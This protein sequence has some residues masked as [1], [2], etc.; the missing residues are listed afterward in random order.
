MEIHSEFIPSLP[1]RGS[2]CLALLTD[3]ILGLLVAVGDEPVQETAWSTLVVVAS[4]CL[5]NLSVE[6]ASGLIIGLVNI[7]EVGY[8][9]WISHMSISIANTRSGG[10]ALTVFI[11]HANRSAK[12]ATDALNC[13]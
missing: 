10:G 6:V 1:R 4:L 11:V 13:A 9:C 8:S 3:L 12:F 5:F 2:L 7:V